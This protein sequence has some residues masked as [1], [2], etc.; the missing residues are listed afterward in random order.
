MDE[1]QMFADLQAEMVADHSNAL[2]DR[3][4]GRARQ[5]IAQQQARG[6]TVTLFDFTRKCM[7]EKNKRRHVMI[8]YC[9]AMWRLI[10]QEDQ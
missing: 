8:A 10:H 9:A 4:L 3:Q 5:W 7:A 6:E 2:L 1:D